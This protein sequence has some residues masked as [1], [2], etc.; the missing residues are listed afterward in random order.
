MP[1]DHRTPNI[2]ARRLGG[3]LRELR[4]ARELSYDG[5][6]EVLGCDAEWLIRLETGFAPVTPDHIR[7]LLD[8]Y[9]VVKH[10]V[11]SVLM[12]LASRRH[13]PPWLAEH[14]ERMTEL[15]RDLLILESE[16][17][18]VRTY[19]IQLIPELVRTEDYARLCF[20]RQI[21]QVDVD[22]EWSL[23]HSR[24]QHRPGGGQ[25]SLD[26]I[27]DELTLR[28]PLSPEIVN[29]QLRHLIDLSGSDHVTVRV[30]PKSRGEHAGL[31]GPFDVLEFP[32]VNDRVSLVHTVLG[33]DLADDD[34]TDIWKVLEDVALSPDDSREL[35]TQILTE[36]QA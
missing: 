12:D 13:G 17:P 18:I 9:Q 33:I 35:M 6:A 5:A 3:Y 20:S 8:G 1:V 2:N 31:G 16:A 4:G 29:G 11:R 22:Q 30:I 15:R 36:D 23:L 26:V 24:Q 27:T 28:K 10:N 19:S 34:L 25:R 21:P 7:I 32:E 14:A